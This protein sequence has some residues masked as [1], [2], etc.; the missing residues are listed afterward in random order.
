MSAIT[1]FRKTRDD[2]FASEDA[3]RI[4]AWAAAFGISMPSDS[5]AFWTSALR[6]EGEASPAMAARCKS[7]MVAKGKE[8]R[9]ED[10]DSHGK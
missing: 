2:V 5:D 3:M 6:T 8:K 1:D 9:K 10:L 7:Q 4:K